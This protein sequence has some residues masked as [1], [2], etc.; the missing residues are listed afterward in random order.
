MAKLEHLGEE[1]RYKPKLKVALIHSKFNQTSHDILPT[2]SLNSQTA[3][4][5]LSRHN[6]GLKPNSPISRQT[7][8]LHIY[9]GNIK[10]LFKNDEPALAIHRNNPTRPQRTPP[11]MPIF[12]F[13][14]GQ[15]L[16]VWI[17]AQIKSSDISSYQHVAEWYLVY[18]VCL[19]AWDISTS[20]DLTSVL[21]AWKNLSGT[22]SIPPM[23][24]VCR[25]SSGSIFLL[26]L[27]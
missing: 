11:Q 12:K 17:F 7:P 25:P 2:S 10:R 5:S 18:I 9:W 4:T 13:A 21:L 14:I 15:R 3:S 20:H 23:P 19:A 6:I 24:L 16:C 27:N 8:Q 26:S 22:M 1:N